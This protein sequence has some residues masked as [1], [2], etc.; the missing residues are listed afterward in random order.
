MRKVETHLLWRSR[1][2]GMVGFRGFRLPKFWR[3]VTALL[4]RHIMNLRSRNA[5]MLPL[6]CNE[7]LEGNPWSTQLDPT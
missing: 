2:W 3:F 7:G 6:P 5:G 4:Q 1:D